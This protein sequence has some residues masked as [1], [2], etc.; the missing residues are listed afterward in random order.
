MNTRIIRN[1]NQLHGLKHLQK[2]LD[3]FFNDFWWPTEFRELEELQP[4]SEFYEDDKNF[5]AKVELPGIKKPDIKINLKNNVLEVSGERKQTRDIKNTK[6]HYSEVY[7]GSY[8]RRFTLPN[9]IEGEKEIRAKFEDGVLIITIPKKVE[10]K[11]VQSIN[12]E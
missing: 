4:L 11:E 9:N 3:N 5:Y 2:S 6:S 10:G 8:M 7:Y 12:I 1:R